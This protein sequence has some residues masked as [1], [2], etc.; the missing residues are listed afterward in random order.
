MF[1]DEFALPVRA[2]GCIGGEQLFAVV[3]GGL[4]LKRMSEKSEVLRA[5]V[6]W[7]QL[8]DS[9]YSQKGFGTRDFA[10]ACQVSTF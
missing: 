10:S 4:S 7:V 5:S 8:P 9:T 2:G 3:G 1:P 6:D